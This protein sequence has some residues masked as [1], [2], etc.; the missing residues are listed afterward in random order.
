MVASQPHP[1]LKSHCL[2]N[3]PRQKMMSV[4]GICGR[5]RV[6]REEKDLHQAL[7]VPL[8]YKG[9]ADPIWGLL[10]LLHN[11]SILLSIYLVRCPHDKKRGAL[12]LDLPQCTELSCGRTGWIL[13]STS[14]CL[15]ASLFL[16]SHDDSRWAVCTRGEERA[17]TSDTAG[18]SHGFSSATT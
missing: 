1:H 4:P 17:V 7:R 15:R 13:Q 2:L 11:S 12:H 16:V 8:A 3:T 14:P 5:M 10:R 9:S 18:H 6:P